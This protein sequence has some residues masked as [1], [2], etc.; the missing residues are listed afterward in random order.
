MNVN[1]LKQDKIFLFMYG[2]S[3]ACLNCCQIIILAILPYDALFAVEINK[4]LGD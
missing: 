3:V 1:G 4:K 2:I